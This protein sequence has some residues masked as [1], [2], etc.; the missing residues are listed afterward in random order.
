MKLNDKTIEALRPIIAQAQMA[1]ARAQEAIRLTGIALGIDVAKT[2]FNID[3]W[4]W[5][6]AQKEPDTK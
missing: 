6:E 2:K 1:N 5:E 3:T 4:T